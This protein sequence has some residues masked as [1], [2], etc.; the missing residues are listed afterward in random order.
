MKGTTTIT[1]RCPKCQRET[2]MIPGE[3]KVKG[4]GGSLL[5]MEFKQT[6]TAHCTKCFFAYAI[7]E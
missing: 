2:F 6:R 7:P 4:R 5:N 1:V 3:W